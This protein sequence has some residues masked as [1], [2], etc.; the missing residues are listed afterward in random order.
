VRRMGGGKR[1]AGVVHNAQHAQG[2]S[3][4]VHGGGVWGN[5]SLYAYLVFLSYPVDE[6]EDGEEVEVVG[7]LLRRCWLYGMPRCADR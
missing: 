3:T 2:A 7:R 6:E 5:T 1:G 4:G